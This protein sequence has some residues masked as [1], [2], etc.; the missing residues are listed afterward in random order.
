MQGE[1]SDRLRPPPEPELERESASNGPRGRCHGRRLR[2]GGLRPLQDSGGEVVEKAE[3]VLEFVG[4]G[5]IEDRLFRELSGGQK[6]RVL[7][8]RALMSDPKLLLLDEPL[9]ALDPSAR[10]E[11]ANVLSKIKRERGVTMIITTH[12]INPLLEIG[13]PRD[14]HKQEADSLW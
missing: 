2:K 4:L 11:V 3:K 8:A 14:A 13:G 9:S 12:D 5:G 1:G 7:L 6:Q 10:A